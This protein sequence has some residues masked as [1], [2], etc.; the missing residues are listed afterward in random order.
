MTH[1][2]HRP[3]ITLTLHSNP[4]THTLAQRTYDLLL[5]TDHVI[6]FIGRDHG[7]ANGNNAGE[8][9]AVASGG[10]SR[11]AAPVGIVAAMMSRLN[12]QDWTGPSVGWS[13][14]RPPAGKSVIL[15]RVP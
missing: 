5:T 8:S 4:L 7:V 3:A 14:S 1:F 6:N 12:F 13:C 2:S 9:G 11:R 15:H 10:A